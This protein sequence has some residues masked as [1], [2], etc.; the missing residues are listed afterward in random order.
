MRMSACHAASGG[1]SQEREFASRSLLPGFI[2]PKTCNCSKGD[3]E[4]PVSYT[5]EPTTYKLQYGIDHQAYAHHTDQL[6][7]NFVELPIEHTNP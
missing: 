4:S 3:R 1:G 7:Y 5:L 2:G 6:L